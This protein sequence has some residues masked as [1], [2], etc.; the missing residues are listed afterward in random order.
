MDGEEVVSGEELY[1]LA[2]RGKRD[3][4]EEALSKNPSLTPDQF[5]AYVITIIT[6]Y[7]SVFFC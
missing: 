3:A 2:R 7:N 4:I 6:H 5:V 1:D